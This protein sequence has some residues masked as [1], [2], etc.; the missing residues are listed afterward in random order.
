MDY[1]GRQWVQQQLLAPLKER[2]LLQQAAY[3]KWVMREMNGS[4]WLLLPRCFPWEGQPCG[5]MGWFAVV[6]PLPRHLP[7]E[8]STTSRYHLWYHKGWYISKV[9]KGSLP[10]WCESVLALQAAAFTGFSWSQLTSQQYLPSAFSLIRVQSQRSFSFSIC[11]AQCPVTSLLRKEAELQSRWDVS[12]HEAHPQQRTVP[13][14]RDQAREPHIPH[15]DKKT[16]LVDR[17]CR[18][19]H[20]ARQQPQQQSPQPH[21]NTPPAPA[22]QRRL[23]PVDSGSR[24]HSTATDWRQS[25][26][27]RR[28]APPSRLPPPPPP[29]H[30]HRWPPA[31]TFP[32]RRRPPVQQLPSAREPTANQQLHELIEMDETDTLSHQRLEGFWKWAEASASLWG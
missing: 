10:Q 29:Y 18:A 30:T 27:R 19:L 15:T 11:S 22:H 9:Y 20:P 25:A 28:T 16:A 31:P 6:A 26:R 21:R 4:A 24:S 2:A 32:S 12:D 13:Q 8:G 1:Q 3:S 14:L 17:I 5:W 7:W 23:Q